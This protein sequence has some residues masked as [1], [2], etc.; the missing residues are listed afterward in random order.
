MKKALF[1]LL[2]CLPFAALAQ[3]TWE[4]PQQQKQNTTQ[5]QPKKAKKVSDEERDAKYLAGAVPEKDGE[6]TWHRTYHNQL[7]AEENYNRMLD[8]FTQLTQQEDQLPESNVALVSKEEHKIVCQICEW[9]VF[10]R[11]FLELDRTRFYYTVI[12]ECKDNVVDIDIIRLHYLY[13]E[14]RKGGTRYKAEELINDESALYKK[15]NKLIKKIAKFRRGT[16][17]RM[18]ALLQDI[19]IKIEAND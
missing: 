4:A 5:Q 18:D 10:T 15:K 11:S 8:Y 16:V 1:T 13:E 19:A 12:I 3:T 14:N 7:S 17:D 6:V 2:C 9:M